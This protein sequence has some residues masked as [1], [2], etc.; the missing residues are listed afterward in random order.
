MQ[1]KKVRQI[2]YGLYWIGKGI[3]TSQFLKHY[4]YKMPPESEAAFKIVNIKIMNFEN[5][6]R[7]NYQSLNNCR[8]LNNMDNKYN[9]VKT[10]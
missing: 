8:L 1:Q 4:N 6:Y 2:L 10:L 9:P 3:F 7:G 5:H